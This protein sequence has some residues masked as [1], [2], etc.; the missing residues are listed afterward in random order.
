VLL[1]EAFR[2]LDRTSR[3]E[4]SRAMRLRVSRATVLEV[5]HDVA[6]TQDFDR[7]L[8][9]EDGRLVEEG[10]PSDLLSTPS[11]YRALVDADL[12]IQR[13]VWNA[14]EWRRIVVEDGSVTVHE[15]TAKVAPAAGNADG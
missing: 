8:V 14:S 4:F 11:R 15:A 13:E 12:A 3:R 6:D 2:G 7:I 9:I 10:A 5:T 1:D